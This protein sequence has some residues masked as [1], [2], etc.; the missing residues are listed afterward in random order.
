MAPRL[1][2]L[3]DIREAYVHGGG[4]HDY[5]LASDYLAALERVRVE[6]RAQFVNDNCVWGE[7]TCTPECPTCRQL[8]ALY[9]ERAAGG[10][11]GRVEALREAREAVG[12]IEVAVATSH[13]LWSRHERAMICGQLNRARSAINRLI[14]AATTGGKP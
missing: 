10:R 12:A 8:D 6:T 4:D 3:S 14:D 7:G 9:N 13:D 1:W 11:E 2:K 5:V